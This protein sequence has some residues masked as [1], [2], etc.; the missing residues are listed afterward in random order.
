M[1]YQKWPGPL[2]LLKGLTKES[3]L[4]TTDPGIE[5]LAGEVK[6]HGS[7]VHRKIGLSCVDAVT[8]SYHVFNENT[9]NL[10]KAMVSSGSI[11]F[12]FPYQ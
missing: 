4:F 11:P 6:K 9:E 5:Y 3:G 2:G 1:V 12:V 10:A 8:G 7:K